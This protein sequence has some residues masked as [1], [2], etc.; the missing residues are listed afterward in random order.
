M[1]IPYTTERRA[2]TRVSNVTMGIWLFIASE[3]MLFGA[4]FSSYALLRTSAPSWPAGRAMLSLPFGASNTILLLMST[5]FAWR[6]RT[7][8]TTWRRS[9]TL[10]TILAALFLTI[11]SVEWAH[12]LSRGYL[13]RVNTFLALYFTLTGLHALHVI[14]GIIANVWAITGLPRVGPEMS[15][16]R[17]YALSVY[18]AF[19]DVVWFLIFA[20]MYLF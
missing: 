15:A 16:G 20:L 12:E 5:T 8:G 19:V 17:V 9:L 10:S 3:V 11:K 4:L 6:A 7:A 1:H 18:W 13:P 14:A 2:D